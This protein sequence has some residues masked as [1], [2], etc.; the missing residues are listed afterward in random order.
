ME[1]LKIQPTTVD[2]G[3]ELKIHWFWYRKTFQIWSSRMVD[4]FGTGLSFWGPR[5]DVLSSRR[6]TVRVPS[7]LPSIFSLETTTVHI[8]KN[9]VDLW[10]CA[11]MSRIIGNCLVYI[12]VIYI[13]TVII[14]SH[15]FPSFFTPSLD[16]IIGTWCEPRLLPPLGTRCQVVVWE[17]PVEAGW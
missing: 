8:Y 17:L 7:G 3:G 6:V 15:F 5:R 1:K 14:G 13:Y 12:W 2:F 11:C 4:W 9:Y 10:I 16:F